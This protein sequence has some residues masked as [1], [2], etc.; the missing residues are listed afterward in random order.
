MS[1]YFNNP[2]KP[3]KQTILR[4][5]NLTKSIEEVGFD[6]VSCLSIKQL[7]ALT[8]IYNKHHQFQNTEGGMFYSIYS[9]DLDYRHR[10]SQEIEEVLK[11]VLDKYCIDFK[12]MLF[13]FVVKLPGKKSEFYLHQDTTGL[14]E[15]K[16]SALNL[17]IPLGDVENANGCLNVVKKSHRWFSPYRS[18]SFPA[19]FDNIQATVKQYLTP[20]EMNKGEVLF[21]DS[22]MLHNSNINYSNKARIAVVCGL[23]PQEATL[24]TCFKENYEL[25]GQVELIKHNDDFLKNGT[26][27]LIDCQK[28]PKTGECIGF[29]EDNYLEISEMEFEKLCKINGIKKN[30]ANTDFE[31][32]TDC[33]LYSEPIS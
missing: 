15:T 19:P 28:R 7:E 12:A 30:N 20:I 14:D 32:K 2:W 23:F 25:G 29:V 21:F 31:K 17:W 33:E 11:P 22:R 8:N 24:I 26:N 13:S 10:V 6:V 3:I 9:Q 5:K 16:Y 4:D 1:I 27:F 18:I